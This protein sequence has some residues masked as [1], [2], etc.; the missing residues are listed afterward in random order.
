MSSTCSDN[1]RHRCVCQI[2]IANCQKPTIFHTSYLPDVPI[3]YYSNSLIASSCCNS[4]I[5]PSCSHNPLIAV[6]LIVP[7]C[8]QCLLT[9]SVPDVNYRPEVDGVFQII[10][11]SWNPFVFVQ[12]VDHFYSSIVHISSQL[13]N[14]SSS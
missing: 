3:T 9:Q 2:L 4:L 6:Y 11:I 7:S 12:T 14:F 10:L 8:C 1:P 13:R 5:A